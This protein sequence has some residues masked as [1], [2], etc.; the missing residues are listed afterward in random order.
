MLRWLFRLL[1]LYGDAKA[2]G[3]GPGAYAK[4]RARRTAYRGIRRL[5][6]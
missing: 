6:R 3:R 4:R 1:G 5:L 2:A